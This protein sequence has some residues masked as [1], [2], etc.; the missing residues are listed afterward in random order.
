M[1]SDLAVVGVGDWQIGILKIVIEDL[2]QYRATVS[3]YHFYVRPPYV[4]S[5]CR[6]PTSSVNGKWQQ[7]KPTTSLSF[8]IPS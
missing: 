7:P 4:S 6:L 3:R 2:I 8:V 5:D 1:G